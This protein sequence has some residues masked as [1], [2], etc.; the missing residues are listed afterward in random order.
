MAFFDVLQCQEKVLLLVGRV[1]KKA[2]ILMQNTFPFYE[3]VNST[4]NSF[5]QAQ[6]LAFSY[7]SFAKG[8][9]RGQGFNFIYATLL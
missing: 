4:S 2:E 6:F 8:I 1:R 7:F 3:I 9:F 5:F